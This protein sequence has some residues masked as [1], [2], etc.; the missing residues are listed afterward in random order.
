MFS[1]FVCCHCRR[2]VPPVA[3]LAPLALVV[4][5]PAPAL[6]DHIS[7]FDAGGIYDSNISNGKFRS[8]VHGDLGFAASTSQGV[9]EQL[10]DSDSISATADLSGESFCRFSGLDNVSLGG[11]LGYRKKFG[12]GAMAPWLSASASAARVVFEND[13]RTGWQDSLALRAGRRI[14]Y[15]WDLSAEIRF[16]KRTADHSSS[17]I[18]G[19]SADVFDTE[20]R[21]LALNAGYAWSGNFLLSLS[22]AYRNGDVVSTTRPNGGIFFSSAAVEEDP[23]FGEGEYAYRLHAT[24]QTVAL[25]ASRVLSENSSLNLGFLRQITNGNGGNNYAKNVINLTYLYSF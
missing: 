20:A 19:I 18:P 13:I 25:R 10:T 12:L 8:D 11:T 17:E 21:S 6:A 5:M 14:D 3:A 9:F 23:A 15:E 16:D 2:L 24:S 7:D 4:L 22:Y 1:A